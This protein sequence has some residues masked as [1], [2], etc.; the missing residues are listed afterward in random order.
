[1]ANLKQLAQS[2]G[3]SI[4]TVSRALDGYSDVAADTRTRVREAADRAG[5]RPNASAR[6][7]RK[8]KA[9]VVAVT[10]PAD[11]GHVAPVH[12]LDMLAGCAEHLAEARL[13]LILAPVPRGGSEVDL[14]RRLVDGRRADAMLLMRTRRQDERVTFLQARG[15]PFVTIGRTENATPHP[16][17]DGDGEAGFRAATERFL[18]AG[19]RRIGHIAAPQDY[20][21]AYARRRGWQGAMAAAGLPVTLI[22]EGQ[23]TEAGGFDAAMTLM[24]QRDGPTALT[25][26]T[27][28]M[29]LGALSALRQIKGG[30]GVAVVGHDDQPIGAFASPPLSSMRID[31]PHLGATLGSL[32]LRA[33]A[34]EPAE[35]LQE[36]RPLAFVDRESHRAPAPTDTAPSDVTS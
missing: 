32:L 31:D 15:T 22:A 10:L 29:A 4:T 12:L 34:G 19:H 9:E 28:E 5:Y 33:M 6:R 11:P 23:P 17:L 14:I 25:C 2:L 30:T 3:L 36:V 26:A 7:L 13:N 1:M 8:Q 21:F 20:Y 16:F 24:M 27:D 18:A 35:A